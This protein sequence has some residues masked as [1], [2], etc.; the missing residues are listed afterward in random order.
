M[1]LEL[2]F[3]NECGFS[4]SVLNTVTNLGIG[5]K[6]TMKNIRENL[7]YE[8]E[9]ISHCGDKT[10]PT[11]MV[12]GSPMRESEAIKGFLVDKFLD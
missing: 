3:H 10:V 5:E 8:K 4:R 6:I 9:L 1:Q 12:D 11:L 2:Y 7:E